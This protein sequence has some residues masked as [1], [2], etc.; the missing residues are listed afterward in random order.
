MREQKKTWVLHCNQSVPQLQVCAVWWQTNMRCNSFLLFLCGWTIFRKATLKGWCGCVLKY[1]VWVS[2]DNFF[3]S[4]FNFCLLCSLLQAR[5][6]SHN[7]PAAATPAFLPTVSQ[8]MWS[9]FYSL[10]IWCW[11]FSVCLLNCFI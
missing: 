1:L 11:H 2:V 8:I 9:W 10:T 7:V 4:P 5:S 6:F 3:F